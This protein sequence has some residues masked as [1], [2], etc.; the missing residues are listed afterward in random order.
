MRNILSLLALFLIFN[1]TVSGQSIQ[2]KT[3]ERNLSQSK[4]DIARIKLLLKVSEVSLNDDPNK[5]ILYAEEAL[6]LSKKLQ[7]EIAEMHSLNKLGFALFVVGNYSR[8]LKVSLEGLKLAK[9]LKNIEGV[10][11]A[12]NTIGNIYRRQGNYQSA[13]SNFL[14]AK[15]ISDADKSIPSSSI[16]STLGIC[17]LET[18]QTDSA[19]VYLQNAYQH[20]IKSKSKG[21][22]ITY[23]RMGDLQYKLNNIPLAVEYYRMGVKS[24][25]LNKQP[26]WLC[27]NYVS[28]A[29]LYLKEN[30]I[31][32]SIVYARKALVL[33]EN[34]FLHQTQKA[35]LL[36]SEDYSQLKQ[37]DSSLKY[38]RLAMV[39]KDT[40]QSNKEESQ[41]QNLVFEERLQKLEEAE[42]QAELKEE[43]SHNLQNSAIAAALI[44]F[45]IAF[46]LLSHSI[47]VNESI[48]R[49]LGI[50]SLLI[51]FE[52]INLL[53]HPYLG[54]LVHHSPVLM[55]C[56]MVSIAALLI[57]LHHK[58]EHWITDKLVK[59]NNGIRL[60]AAKK[61]IDKIEGNN[62][63]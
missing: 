53:L 6:L 39:I 15:D 60:A 22:S 63:T 16:I 48:I 31:D 28:L 58:L 55:L 26:R 45:I 37:A 40:I 9:K 47:L 51:V 23:N 38:L 3:P 41:I 18:G 54:G 32:S 57:P 1:G 27:F 36:I 62:P 29:E 46:L 42:K 44:L 14:L 50:L 52:F 34:K 12:Y 43:R 4:E 20:D 13:I 21:I 30:Q 2:I 33:G 10:V 25:H 59:K 49:F 56:I 19:M 11:A 8:G 61:I 24:A 5:S 7:S 35:S 17:Y